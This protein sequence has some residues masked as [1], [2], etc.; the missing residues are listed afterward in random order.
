MKLSKKILSTITTFALSATLL[1]GFSANNDSQL[2]VSAVSGKSASEITSDMTIGWNL[3]NSLD[4]HSETIGFDTSPKA[5]AVSWGNPAPTKELFQTVKNAGFNTVRIPTTWYTHIRYNEATDNYDISP[6]WLD[7]VQTV[8]DY[9]YDLDMYVILNLHHEE[10]L[11]NRDVFT[12]ETLADTMKKMEDIW[13]VVAERFKD[14]DQRLIFE[15]MNEPRQKKNSNVKEWGDGG[16]DGGYTWNYINT[17]NEMFINIVRGTEGKGNQERLLMIPGYCAT[18]SAT[19]LNNVNVPEGSGNVALSVHAYAPYFFTMADSDMANHNFPGNSGY[20][21]SYESELS[22]LFS[23][24]KSVMDSKGVQIIIGE[25]SASDFNNTESRVNWA[26]S[27][28]SKSE[29]AGIPCVL[30]DNNISADGS[31]ESHGY[32]YRETNTIFPESSPVLAA[33]MDTVGVTDYVLPEYAEYV[34]PEFSWDDIEIGDNWIEM[35]RSEEGETAAKWGNVEIMNWKDTVVPSNTKYAL[36]VDSSV[37]PGL[38]FQ[39]NKAEWLRITADFDLSEGF[40]LYFTYD[41]IMKV[42][43]SNKLTLDNTTNVHVGASS[44][45]MTVYGLYAIPEDGATEPLKGD[46]NGDGKVSLDDVLMVAYYIL[47]KDVDIDTN[48][49]DLDG[50]GSVSVIDLTILKRIILDK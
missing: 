44:A 15:A 40:V 26:K 13:T 8:V 7:Y 19:A 24:L 22:G 12:D 1:C 48:L 20:G 35:F 4:A 43:N 25:F 21:V 6:E 38:I 33:M 47:G 16:D 41:D 2:V 31:G 14:Y 39:G 50:N 10:N 37:Q 27:Y 45:E 9:A 17:I 23:S 3:G 34:A 49:A 11:V 46:V 29:A 32:I 18:S 36:I 30:W 5:S 42:L 28:L